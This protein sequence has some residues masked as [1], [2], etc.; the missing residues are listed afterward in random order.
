M[1]LASF[2]VLD[3]GESIL[4]LIVELGWRLPLARLLLLFETRQ[5]ATG[6]WCCTR[7]NDGDK[8]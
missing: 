2:H 8:L 6:R 5:N 3:K 4:T 7:W 1:D